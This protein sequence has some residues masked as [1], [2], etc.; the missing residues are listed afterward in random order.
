MNSITVLTPDGVKRTIVNSPN[1]IKPGGTPFTHNQAAADQPPAQAKTQ[2]P[3]QAAGGAEW[4]KRKGLGAPPS[5]RYVVNKAGY[6]Y[7]L[8]IGELIIQGN[9][10]QGIVRG[11]GA[12]APYTLDGDKI[13]WTN[14]LEGLPH[15]APLVTSKYIGADEHGRALI[16]IWYRGNRG[17]LEVLDAYRVGQ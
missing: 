14:G 2:Q 17:A 6:G 1:W 10:Y 9:T 15:N 7:G 3:R 4:D 5:G 13:V 12:S 8:D 16:R 11:G